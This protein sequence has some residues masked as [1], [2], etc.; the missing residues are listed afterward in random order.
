MFNQFYIDF[1]D[2]KRP[3]LMQYCK[4]EHVLPEELV[5]TGKHRKTMKFHLETAAFHLLQRLD[6]RL[7][8]M[9]GRL[10]ADIERNSL[11]QR[12]VS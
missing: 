8:A 1:A 10:I 12:H 11:V 2:S 4:R 6:R 3:D 7:D 9:I 5:Y